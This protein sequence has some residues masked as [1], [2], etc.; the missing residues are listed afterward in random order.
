MNG[1]RFDHGSDLL[2]LPQLHVL[3]ALVGDEGFER[4]TT[5]KTDAH[6]R[7]FAI[8]GPNVPEQT[9]ARAALRRIGTTLLQHDVL[10]VDADIDFVV[11]STVAMERCES[12]HLLS[13]DLDGC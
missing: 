6:H 13:A 7:S 3:A 10:G 12:N 9:V 5:L 2:P 8:Q 4:K 11:R 1:R